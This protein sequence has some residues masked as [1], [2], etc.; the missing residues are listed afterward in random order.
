MARQLQPGFMGEPDELALKSLAAYGRL[1]GLILAGLLSLGKAHAAATAKP[2][3]AR[4]RT[5]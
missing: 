1:F 5:I 2:T 4:R 3:W